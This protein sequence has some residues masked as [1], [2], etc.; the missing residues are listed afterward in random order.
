[1]WDVKI[2]RPSILILVKNPDGTDNYD[3]TRGLIP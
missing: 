3:I 1:M 2:P